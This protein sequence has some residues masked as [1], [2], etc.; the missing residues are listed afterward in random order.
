M[1]TA[2]TLYRFLIFVARVIW[3]ERARR[4]RDCPEIMPE[5]NRHRG[6][7]GGLRTSPPRHILMI[8]YNLYP[9]STYPSKYS[10]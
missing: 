9:P 4:G 1:H 10:R 7:R 8:I 3:Y 6:C 2:H 5:T